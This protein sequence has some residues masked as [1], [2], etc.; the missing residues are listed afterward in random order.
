MER[1]L[2]KFGESSLALVI[3]K[4][5]TEK[6]SLS[7]KN[8]IYLSESDGGD[9]VISPRQ[10]T[11][12]ESEIV[13]DAHN[14][15]I[16]IG[17]WVELHYLYGTNKLRIY[18]PDGIEQPKIEAIESEITR[19]CP[20]FVVTSQSSKEIIIEDFM[21]MKEQSLEKIIGRLK[22]LVEYEFRE[23]LEGDPK[24]IVGIEEIVNRFYM[25]G[26]RYVFVTQPKDALKYFRLLERIEQISDNM[27]KISIDGKTK[28]KKIFYDLKTQ[29]ETGFSGFYGNM[30][31]ISDT[32]TMRAQIIDKI[33]KSK[34]DRLDALSIREISNHITNMSEFGLKI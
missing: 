9:L 27:E 2:F 29:F 16:I 4:K 31:A 8:V 6:N 24:N 3:P 5:W 28:H 23:I 33:S 32:A 20:G 10:R 14:N 1:S 25:M 30:K 17:R 22:S 34:M 26:T 15:S 7:A 13:I 19:N 18:A 21:D 12:S 11:R